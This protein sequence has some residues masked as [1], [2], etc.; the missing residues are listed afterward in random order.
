MQRYVERSALQNATQVAQTFGM[1]AVT[2]NKRLDEFGG[3]YNKAVKRG[4]AFCQ[5]WIDKGLGEMKQTAQGYPQ[6]LFTTKGAARV[7]EIMTTEGVI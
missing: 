4:R 7:H 3:V 2:M 5:D 6:A 1:S